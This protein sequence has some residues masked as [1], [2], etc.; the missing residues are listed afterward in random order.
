MRGQAADI[1][2]PDRDFNQMHRAAMSL[3][4]GG[5]GRYRRSRFIH[6]DTGAVRSWG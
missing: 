2:M 3:S 5:V 1:R 6:L 4:A